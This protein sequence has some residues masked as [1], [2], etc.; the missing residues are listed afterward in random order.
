MFNEV[1]GVETMSKRNGSENDEICRKGKQPSSQD[2]KIGTNALI[3][4]NFEAEFNRLLGTV[5]VEYLKHE[6]GFRT[7][8]LVENLL[9]KRGTTLYDIGRDADGITDPLYSFFGDGA[10]IVVDGLLQYLFYV[11]GSPDEESYTRFDIGYA[12]EKLKRYA[13]E[14]PALV[15]RAFPPIVSAGL[16]R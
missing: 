6:L 12:I 15:I 1:A 10:D 3:K 4:S 13:S 7:T 11:F 8:E 9:N 5:A 16:E 2:A 14:N